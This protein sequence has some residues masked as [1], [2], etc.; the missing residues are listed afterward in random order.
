MNVNVDKLEVM[1]V[2]KKFTY[3]H[4]HKWDFFQAQ[5]SKLLAG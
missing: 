1:L 2:L 5:K 4:L 3:F